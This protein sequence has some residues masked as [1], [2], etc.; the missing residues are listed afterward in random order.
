M[1]AP[2]AARASVRGEVGLS[3]VLKGAVGTVG[4]LGGGGQLKPGSNRVTLHTQNMKL[5][6]LWG[7]P[8]SIADTSV[9][10]DNQ[11]VELSEI[12]PIPELD[13]RGI[14]G[15]KCANDSNGDGRVDN[16]DLPAAMASIDQEL[17]VMARTPGYRP[18]PIE[19]LRRFQQEMIAKNRN[20]RTK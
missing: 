5:A 14:P 2:R 8:H 4:Y 1:P 15:A 19:N 18:P 10:Y 17:A 12:V 7:A 20:C 13:F 3:A 6:W 11:E 16:G 9:R